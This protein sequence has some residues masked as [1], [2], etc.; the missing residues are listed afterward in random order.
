M[1]GF[2]VSSRGK[3]RPASERARW[4]AWALAGVAV[5][6]CWSLLESLAPASVGT[7]ELVAA[8]A[9]NLAAVLLVVAGVMWLACWRLNGDR[10]TAR[11]AVA[12][13]VLGVGLPEVTA[14][15]PLLHETGQLALFAPSTR[16]L[17]VIP[18][19]ALLLP[20]RRWEGLGS[21]R[22]TGRAYGVLALVAT[23]A[24]LAG[25]VVARQTLPAG[26][27]PVGWGALEG[28]LAL[29]WLL[30]AVRARTLGRA[31]ARGLAVSFGLLALCELLRLLALGGTMPAKGLAPG[32]QLVA[33]GLV[34]ATAAGEL[35]AAHRRQEEETADLIGSLVTV[36]QAL[37]RL[38]RSGRERLHDARSA[39]V[40]VIGAA[41][42]LTEPRPATLSPQESG[43]R[44]TLDAD[45]LRRLIGAELRRLQCLLDI[46]PVDEPADV[47]LAESLAAVVE[48]H[49]LDGLTVHTELAPLVVRGRTQAIATGLDNLLRNVRRHAPGAQAWVRVTSMGGQACVVVED[50][51]PGIPEAEQRRVLQPGLRGSTARGPGDGLGLSSAV[52]A[53]AAQDGSLSVDRAPSGGTRVTLRLPLAPARP[54]VIVLPD[55]RPTEA[56]AG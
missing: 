8:V 14:V 46:G 24:G 44:P 13:L 33:A 11:V 42:L 37:T 53:M 40:G 22:P 12:M 38:E 9:K 41:E 23:G 39:V 20:A 35:R 45:E 48:M 21:V 16:A 55:S 15:G 26:R 29:A 10:L 1:T 50:D 51:G 32:C 19:L 49:R 17:L 54:T 25:L 4:W 7:Q 56:L 36:R 30:L 5:L 28:L 31:A 27:L 47:D 2:V 18:V 43:E 52:A 6:G 3:V 34:F